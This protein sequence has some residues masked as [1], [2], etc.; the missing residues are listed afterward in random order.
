M[1]DAPE[2]SQIP[3]LREILTDGVFAPKIQKVFNPPLNSL[4]RRNAMQWLVV[5]IGA[6]SLMGLGVTAGIYEFFDLELSGTFPGKGVG[7]TLIF[8]LITSF[9]FVVLERAENVLSKRKQ[10]A[11]VSQL[12]QSERMAVATALLQRLKAADI[13]RF[14]DQSAI[15]RGFDAGL[16]YEDMTSPVLKQQQD[17]LKVLQE[18][19]EQLV[20]HDKEAALKAFRHL[21][22]WRH[23]YLDV[24][25]S[26]LQIMVN[27]FPADVDRQIGEKQ[28]SVLV[29]RLRA[30]AHKSH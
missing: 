5:I 24:W 19:S 8:I 26:D 11:V 29:E 7:L 17:I 4:F 13:E 28:D 21:F 1:S 18:F 10:R 9:L 20:S 27:R 15:E 3:F 23:S 16:S 30:E 25:I 6:C 14:L 2:S 12:S 22:A